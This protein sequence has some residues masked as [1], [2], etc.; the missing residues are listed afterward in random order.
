MTYTARTWDLR[1]FALIAVGAALGAAWAWFNLSRAGGSGFSAAT[2][3][4]VWVVFATPFFTFWGWLL[5]RR[6]EVW[7]ALF[8]CFCIYFFGILIG[9]RLERLLLGADAARAAGHALY[10]QLTVAIQLGACLLAALQRSLKRGTMPVST[11][12]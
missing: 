11:Q 1:A 6:R 9:A 12:G 3:P 4:L 10:F 7:L 2:G 5:A 8:V